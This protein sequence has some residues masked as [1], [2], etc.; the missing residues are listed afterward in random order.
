MARD[1]DQDEVALRMLGRLEV[2]IIPV[3]ADLDR[4]LGGRVVLASGLDAD[5]RPQVVVDGLGI[6]VW[7]GLD[8]TDAV[9]LA[10]TADSVQAEIMDQM[11]ERFWPTCREHGRGLHAVPQ[12]GVAAWTCRDGPHVVAPVGELDPA[13]LE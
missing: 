10:E 6:Y 2:A 9:L 12:A 7:L 1:P 3:Q 13:L 8:A 5:G 11:V 4:T